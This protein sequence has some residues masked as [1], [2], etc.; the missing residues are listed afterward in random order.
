MSGTILG[1]RI[2]VTHVI[3]SSLASF[4]TTNSVQP[5][6][7]VHADQAVG[8]AGVVRT[9]QT[10][11]DVTF[12]EHTPFADLDDNAYPESAHDLAYLN[13]AD[14]AAGISHPS[15]HGG[16]KGEISDLYDYF[17][18]ACFEDIS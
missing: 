11:Y 15:P 17:A 4:K 13:R 7:W 18:S 14:V 2:P 10:R 3:F 12:G 5:E 1:E 8:I 9:Q 6:R 16:V